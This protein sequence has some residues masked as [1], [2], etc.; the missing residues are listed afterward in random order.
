[1]LTAEYSKIKKLQS[2]AAK[3]NFQV[4]ITYFKAY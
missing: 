3:S 2:F 1:M 4:F